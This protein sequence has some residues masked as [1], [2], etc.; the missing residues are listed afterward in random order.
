MSHVRLFLAVLLVLLLQVTVVARIGI[1]G[2]QPDL[3]VLLLVL[4]ALR[5]GPIAGTL[6]GFALGLVQDSLVPP[7]MGMNMLAKSLTGYA[8]GQLSDKLVVGGPA[9]QAALVGGAVLL[10]DFFYLLAFTGLD[11]L[12][13][14]RMYFVQAVPAALYT[15]VVGLAVL[16]ATG[17]ARA[18]GPG[19]GGHREAG[20]GR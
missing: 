7:T 9:L 10:H 19:L 15:A 2:V 13:F 12:T 16:A 17:L 4:V 5:R 3:M 1:L 8:V 18:G 6:L 11:L 20:L 14:V